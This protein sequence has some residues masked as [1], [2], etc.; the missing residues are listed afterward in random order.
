MVYTFAVIRVRPIELSINYYGGG[1]TS[2]SALSRTRLYTVEDFRMLD[3]NHEF[4]K[5]MTDALYAK[6]AFDLSLWREEV[7]EG[8]S[9]L[10]IDLRRIRKC[11]LLLHDLEATTYFPRTHVWG[12]SFPLLVP[13]SA[14]ACGFSNLQWASDGIHARRVRASKSEVASG[15]SKTNGYVETHWFDTFPFLS[16]RDISLLQISGRPHD[17]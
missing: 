5:E 1:T 7:G 3:T 16:P 15:M 14:S 17:G 9:L 2:T 13:S 10:Q 12:G 4:R 6:N 11:R 8:M